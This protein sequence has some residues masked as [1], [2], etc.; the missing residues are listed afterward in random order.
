MKLKKK[1]KKKKD[2]DEE[3]E[4]IRN[5]FMDKKIYKKKDVFTFVGKSKKKLKKLKMNTINQK[6]NNDIMIGLS[7]QW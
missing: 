2:L 7:T 5:I 1:Q 6:N 3:K 4:L